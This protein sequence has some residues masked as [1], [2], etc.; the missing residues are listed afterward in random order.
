M[1]CD[2][3]DY[4]NGDDDEDAG[5]RKSA[6]GRNVRAA[7]ANVVRTQDEEDDANNSVG[8]ACD[9]TIMVILLLMRICPNVTIIF[10]K[11]DDL[12]S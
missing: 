11:G 5:S 6:H 2:D 3:D 10:H 9:L 12:L 4:S 1:I 7:G 8:L